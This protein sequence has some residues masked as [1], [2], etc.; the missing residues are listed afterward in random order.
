[1][2]F[3]RCG[4]QIANQAKFKNY[5]KELLLH[6]VNKNICRYLQL[7]N[8]FLIR[9]HFF[10]LA[11]SLV[12]SDEGVASRLKWVCWRV[13][14]LGRKASLWLIRNIPKWPIQHQLGVHSTTHQRL[15]VIE[16]DFSDTGTT[17]ARWN[18]G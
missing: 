8:I 14:F 5:Q 4:S 10:S 1:M 7:E 3:Q 9:K 16:A 11:P 13:A 12:E 2:S 17:S 15:C 6:L 18:I